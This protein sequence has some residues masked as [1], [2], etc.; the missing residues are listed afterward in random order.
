MAA[1]LEPILADNRMKHLQT[2]EGKE[3]Y[4]SVVQALLKKYNVNHYSTYSEKKASIVERFNRTLKTRMYRA[5]TEHGNYRWL[6][7]LPELV[8]A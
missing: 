2:D 3:Y 7:L 1:A 6:D 4:N 5:F 8:A